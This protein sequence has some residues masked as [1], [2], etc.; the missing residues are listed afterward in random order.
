[1][2]G[3]STR[4]SRDCSFPQVTCILVAYV[5][6]QT[7][8][9]RR[10]GS[11]RASHHRCYSADQRHDNNGREALGV[12]VMIQGYLLYRF[13]QYAELKKGAVKCKG[14]IDRH[15]HLGRLLEEAGGQGDA[16]GTSSALLKQLVKLTHLFRHLDRVVVQVQTCRAS[17]RV[18]HG[19]NG[20]A[21]L[22][23]H[24]R[25]DSVHRGGH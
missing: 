3:R 14:W 18:S 11:P 15:C 16:N 8:P 20:A 22:A 25:L 5:F 6:G 21:T 23:H 9:K 12:V 10:G 1:M 4:P 2:H 7:T 24:L 19:G 13:L 17:V